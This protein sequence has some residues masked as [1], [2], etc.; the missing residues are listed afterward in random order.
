MSSAYRRILIQ[1]YGL[2]LRSVRLR[3]QFRLK[4]IIELYILCY[5]GI[6]LFEILEF[7]RPQD[8]EGL[9]PVSLPHVPLCRQP[10]Y[11]SLSLDNFEHELKTHLFEQQRTSSDAAVKFL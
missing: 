7:R 3:A 4:S 5:Y 6:S 11:N 8:D 2:Y 10:F 9:P 1:K